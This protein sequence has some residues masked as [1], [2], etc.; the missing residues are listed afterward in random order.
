MLSSS[1]STASFLDWKRMFL[2][3]HHRCVHFWSMYT[4]TMQQRILND[5]QVTPCRMLGHPEPHVFTQ[6]DLLNLW[7][8]LQVKVSQAWSMVWCLTFKKQVVYKKI[9]KFLYLWPSLTYYTTEWKRISFAYDHEEN[10]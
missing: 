3:H 4:F 5:I 2:M 8:T 10:V 9:E 6:K 1:S 7:I